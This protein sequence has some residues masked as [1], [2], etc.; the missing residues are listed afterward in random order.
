MVI[1][2]DEEEA[3]ICADGRRLWRVLEMFSET[4]QNTQ[5]KIQEFTLMSKS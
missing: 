4:Y 1:N 5:W 3:I 2:F